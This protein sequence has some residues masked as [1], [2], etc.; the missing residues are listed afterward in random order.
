[1]LKTILL[2]V[3]AAALSI[4]TTACKQKK[5]K[6]APGQ[7]TEEE[8]T[9]LRQNAIKAYEDIVAKYPDSQ[10]AAMAQERLKVLRP[11]QKK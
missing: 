5:A 7:M 11:E 10:Y 3:I 1:M 6:P 8:R 2:F 4:G 9:K